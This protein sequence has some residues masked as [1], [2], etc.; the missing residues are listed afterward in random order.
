MRATRNISR[1]PVAVL[2]AVAVVE[3]GLVVC[4]A[5]MRLP[6]SMLRAVTRPANGDFTFWN[7][8]KSSRRRTLASAAATLASATFTFASPAVTVASAVFDAPS[9]WSNSCCDSEAFRDLARL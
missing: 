6:V 8:C 2:L 9:N 4:P 7:D 3:L 1:V 5:V